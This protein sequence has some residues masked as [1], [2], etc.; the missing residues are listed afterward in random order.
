MVPPT[1]DAKVSVLSTRGAEGSPAD[2]AGG[3]GPIDLSGKSGEGPKSV[4]VVVG[5]V[6]T[7][8]STSEG[9]KPSVCSQLNKGRQGQSA[10]LMSNGDVFIAGGEQIV[11][12][13]RL[14]LRNTE[15]YNAQTGAFTATADL[16]EG[17][18]YHTATLLK[19]GKVLVCGGLGVLGGRAVSLATCLLFDS[20][21][22]RFVEPTLALNAG[23]QQHTAT[24]LD[25]QRVV[26]AGGVGTGADF[27]LS[28]EVYDP[29]V[30]GLEKLQP[31][32]NMVTARAQH[33]ATLLNDGATVVIA[34]GRDRDTVKA[35]V[36]AWTIAMSRRIGVYVP[37][38]AH[39]AAK[40]PDGRVVFAGGFNSIVDNGNPA[41]V[42][43][44]EIFDP[45]GGGSVSCGD[46]LQLGTPR[47]SLFGEALPISSDGVSR[48]VVGGGTL[49]DGS[50]THLAEL[51]TL[52]KAKNCT[53]VTITA[54]AAPMKLLRTRASSLV[55]PGGDVLIVGGSQSIGALTVP[56]ITGE[57]FISPR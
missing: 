53:G 57:I 22:R 23:R 48:V 27:L 47:G 33:T 13:E 10:T 6:G 14:L 29:D 56:A 16:P 37:R 50:A 24:L 12:G 31:G 3:F 35:D 21:T 18:A 30:E 4:R 49:I 41:T 5:R 7:F 42:A 28:T 19:N 11:N 43:T 51:I 32:P 15:V 25:D 55:L 46:T 20:Q 52:P 17:R 1:E 34:G 2:V 8:N 9:P 40:A 38:Y 44:V 26:I 36:E 45:A 54:T 39:A